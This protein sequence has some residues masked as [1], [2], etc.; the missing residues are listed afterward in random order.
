MEKGPEHTTSL[1]KVAITGPE[2]TGKSTLTADLASWYNS[3]MVPEFAR[4][5]LEQ[6]GRPY[7]MADVEYIAL[8]QVELE[9]LQSVKATNYLFCDTELINI[10]IWMVHKYGTCPAWIINSIKIPQYNLYL[11]CDIDIPWEPDTLRENPHDRQHFFDLFRHM[12][13]SLHYP[14]AIISGNRKQRLMNAIAAVD[15]L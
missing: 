10:R 15:A 6:L 8:K 7:Q 12:L 13:D 4:S 11:L 1:I 14:Y 9:Y 2:S 3:L 5:Y